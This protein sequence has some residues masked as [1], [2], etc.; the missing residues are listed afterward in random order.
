MIGVKRI[1]YKLAWSTTVFIGSLATLT[2][3]AAN[4]GAQSPSL[5]VSGAT[6]APGATVTLDVSL[7]PGGTLPASVQWDL[8]YSTSDLSL[9]AGTY[10]AIGTAG[11]G[12]GKSV[13]CN[14]ISA[15][16]IRCIVSGININAIGN[17]VLATLT[18]TIASGTTDNSTPVSLVSPEASDGS[19]NALAVTGGGAT[20]TINHVAVGAVSVTPSSGSGSQPNFCVAI[21]RLQP[22]RAAWPGCGRGSTPR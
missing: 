17:G 22:E 5:S 18:F 3:L 1:L 4:A 20:V 14:S 10:D 8:T 13:V 7:N 9:V 2:T 15:G 12:A 16:D 11:S 19:A 6:G 21:F